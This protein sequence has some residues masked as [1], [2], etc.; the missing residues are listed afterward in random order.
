M[1]DDQLQC[2]RLRGLLKTRIWLVLWNE[3]QS[4]PWNRLHELSH[5]GPQ[6]WRDQLREQLREDFGD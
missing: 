3:I 5:R 6:H 2:W 1:M 4:D